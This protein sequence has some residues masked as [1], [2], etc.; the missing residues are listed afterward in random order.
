LLSLANPDT[1]KAQVLGDTASLNLVK[2]SVSYIYNMRFS[3]AG[4]TCSKINSIYPGHPV[5]LLLRGMIIY[6]KNYPLISNS[7][8]G[9]EFEDKMH[10]CIDLCETSHSKNEA[11]M[12]LVNLCARGILLLY[13]SSNNLNS[14]IFSMGGSTYRLV[15]HSFDFTGTFS[16][17]YFFTG[18]YNYYREVY[19]DFHPV[20]KSVFLLLPR[21]NR[22]KGLEELRT[23]F[24]RSIFLKAESS[25]FLS[26]IYKYFENDFMKAS[27]FSKTLYNHY[28]AN[29]VYLT[30]CI[31]DLLLAG[32][33]DEA[34]KII[35]SAESG[36]KN[37][38]FESMI[39]I[40]K[41]IV[42]EKKYKDLKK[43]S[44][45]YSSGATSILPYYDYGAQ[46]AAYAY[47]G[48]SRISALNHDKRNQRFYRRKAM[49]LTDFRNVN[50][51]K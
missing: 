14:K 37:R 45:E 50:F 3:D 31:E 22:E 25:S 6:W 17:F 47:F 23:A 7:P 13:Y 15:R 40:F 24:E 4:E 51:D 11:E 41:G 28:P 20:Y 18:L 10:H 38:Y 36:T 49:D 19:P 34:E 8:A 2:E 35:L 12:L 29:I 9:P 42:D 32:K 48:L 5:V 44:Q 27:Y 16:D 46:Y 33:Y 43:A 39:T 21:G 1:L 30:D 26:S